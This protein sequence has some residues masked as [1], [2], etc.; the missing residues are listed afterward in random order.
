MN[1]CC[2]KTQIILQLDFPLEKKHLQLFLNS[3][4]IEVKNYIN[5]GIMFVE[6]TNLTASGPI[7]SNRLQIRC[8]TTDCEKSSIIIENIINNI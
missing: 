2:G 7:G 1:A 6:D 5:S 8:K 4:F 3:N